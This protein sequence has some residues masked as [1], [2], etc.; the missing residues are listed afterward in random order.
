[1]NLLKKNLFKIMLLAL[2]LS[3]S[4]IFNHNADFWIG[5]EY[6]YYQLFFT[7]SFSTIFFL[8][9]K[10]QLRLGKVDIAVISIL[11]F[12]AISRSLRLGSL[13]EIHVINTI[14]LVIY[15]IS[16]K[17]IR[18]KKEETTTYYQFVIGIGVFLCAY[19]MLELYD[20]IE[21]TNFYWRMTGNFPNPG[22]LGGFIAVI[23]SLVFY[24]LLQ[25]D[26][27]KKP[28]KIL[29]Y[30]LVAIIILFVLI[31]SASR[32]AMLSTVIA[33]T[34][35]AS[36]YGFKKWNHFKYT[37]LSLLPI[38]IFIGLSKGTDSISGRLLIW[39][40]SL[41]SFLDHPLAGIG[42]GFFG[43]EYLNFQADYF[44]KGG[45]TK[46]ILL[47]AVN[48]QAF[49]EFL[50]FV[51]EN[52][53]WGIILIIVALFWI[54]K[55]KPI[56]LISNQQNFPLASIAFYSSF[57]VFACFSFPLQ[58]LAF[59][60]LLL[61]QIGLQNYPP[62]T[63]NFKTNKN[64]QKIF[65]TTAACLLI[66]T[67]TSHHKAFKAWKEASELQFSNPDSTKTLYK[68]AYQ[69]LQNDAA[70]LVRYGNF[71][72]DKS[73]KTSLEL[74][75]KAKLLANIPSLYSKTA[76]LYEKQHD[77]KNAETNLLKLHYINPHLFKPQE[78]LLD[79]YT[80][81]SN[82]LKAKYY[83]TKILETPI[84]I[85]GQEVFRIKQKAKIFLKQT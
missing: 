36:Y 82:A 2:F 10:E 46:E 32:A 74:F 14:S 3:L 68:N 31:K 24:E 80:H 70:F 5:K 49:N 69:E 57:A 37:L 26:I 23:L 55:S 66:F 16:L 35:I 28:G 29:L 62:L 47:A 15:Y 12:L 77:Y 42:Y 71:N 33:I 63:L 65:L 50:K 25:K 30:S 19:C 52:G 38:F 73:N 40:I 20:V 41:L 85:P 79:F 72:E 39:K 1:M 11:L 43:V 83:A 8:I 45:T 60:L 54:L 58:F 22:P 9:S 17:T 78:A 48:E 76:K 56:I 18:L 27:I 84:K 34:V 13:N 67:I 44:S 64:F 81:R 51:V 75:E 7:V 6:E 4:L 59:K 21:P 53:I 61:N